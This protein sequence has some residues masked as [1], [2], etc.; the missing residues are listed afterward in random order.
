MKR[1][2]EPIRW[3][4]PRS[5]APGELRRWIA[6]GR[7][8]LGPTPEQL[9]RLGEFATATAAGG[10][11]AGGAAGPGAGAAKVAAVKGG[12]ALAKVGILKVVAALAVAGAGAG[13]GWSVLH[14]TG[15][16]PAPPA[17][18]RPVD[19]APKAASALPG[20]QVAPPPEDAVPAPSTLDAPPAASGTST[21]PAA[22]PLSPAPRTAP[23]AP[24]T[25]VVASPSPSTALAPGGA[26]RA[27]GPTGPSTTTA[28]ESELSLLDRAHARMGADP[29]GALRALEEHRSRY[30]Q[31][32]F[33]Q[34]REVL[35]IEALVHLGRRK[36]AEARAAAFATQFPGSA[37]RRRIA[38]LLALDGGP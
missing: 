11:A 26:P 18:E 8:A 10:A 32:T 4:D 22:V 23:P 24:A 27:E 7:D 25:G 12:Q 29:A 9:A 13:V 6:E 14:G 30:P 21:H 33:A 38:V 28:G 20:P 19:E 35:A 2:E 37:H 16:P 3:L 1:F 34:E 15:A 31:G 36:E 5:D 17:V